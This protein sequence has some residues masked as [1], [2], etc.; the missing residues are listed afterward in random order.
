MSSRR[1]NLIIISVILVA[2]LLAI[3]FVGP[4]ESEDSKA[5]LALS[6]VYLAPLEVK[7]WTAVVKDRETGEGVWGVRVTVKEKDGAVVGSAATLPPN[8]AVSF[9]LAEGEYDISVTDSRGRYEPVNFTLIGW[10][11]GVT[12]EIFLG[13]FTVIELSGS[14]TDKPRELSLKWKNVPGATSYAVFLYWAAEQVGLIELDKEFNVDKFGETYFENVFDSGFEQ[15]AELGIFVQAFDGDELIGES[16]VVYIAPLA[17]LLVNSVY[18]GGGEIHGQVKDSSEGKGLDSVVIVANKDKESPQWLDISWQ[19]PGAEDY[20][21]FVWKKD[22]PEDNLGPFDSWLWFGS[23]NAENDLRDVYDAGSPSSTSFGQVINKNTEEPDNIVSFSKIGSKEI[24]EQDGLVTVNYAI[25][26]GEI[27]KEFVRVG[28]ARKLTINFKQKP[29]P[30]PVPVPAP[31]GETILET[32]AK[33]N[34]KF[35]ES[36]FSKIRLVLSGKTLKYRKVLI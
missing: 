4:P 21:I 18:W 8:Y 22:A 10:D 7:Q 13:G 5:L 24:F 9:D 23:L 1:R 2:A 20:W 34:K 17:G 36:I 3:N 35:V 27:T 26:E 6:D 30:V 15:G 25:F 32:L 14:A 29:E 31:V 19:K 11:D 28:D 16:R 12:Q 33:I